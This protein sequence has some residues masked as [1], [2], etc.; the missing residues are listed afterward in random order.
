MKKGATKMTISEINIV[1]VKPVN[2]FVAFASCVVNEQ[3]YLGS[4]GVHKR[5]DGTGYRITYPTK[6]VGSR[7]LNFYH[8]LTSEVGL[9]IERAITNKCQELF[10]RSDEEYGRYDKVTHLST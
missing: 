2:G 3:I 4:L 9:T 10:E 8:P 6:R 7:E 1:P 5:L